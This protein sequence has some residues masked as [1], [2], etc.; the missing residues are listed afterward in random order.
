M[1]EANELFTVDAIRKAVAKIRATPYMPEVTFLTAREMEILIQL[2]KD[3]EN[4]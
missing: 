1:N 2:Q 4:E 3:A